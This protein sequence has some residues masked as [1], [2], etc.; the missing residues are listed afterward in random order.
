[1]I[2]DSLNKTVLL[3]KAPVTG[4]VTASQNFVLLLVIIIKFCERHFPFI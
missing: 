3:L 4:F 2:C 1:M